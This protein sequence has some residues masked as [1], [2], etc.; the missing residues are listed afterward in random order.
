[1]SDNQKSPNFAFLAKHAP[2]LVD[3]AALAER[4]VFE[5]PNSALIKL[6]QLCEM[7]VK[8]AA[9][10]SGIVTEERDSI[11]VIINRLWDRRIINHDISSL[12]HDLRKAGNEAAHAHLDDRRIA[13]YQLQMARKLAVWFHK[14]F[15]KDRNF[16]AGPFLPPPDPV[17]Q[18]QTLVDELERLRKKVVFAEEQLSEEKQ[19]SEAQQQE[20]SEFK[21][22]VQEAY[23]NEEAALE[24]AADYEQRLQQEREEFEQ[25]L[26]QQQAEWATKTPEEQEAVTQHAQAEAEAFSLDEAETRQKIDAQLREAGWDA[27]SQ[28]LKYSAGI[29]PVKGRNIAIAE[30]PTK[31]GPADYVLFLGLT[32]VAVVEAKRKNKNVPASIEQSKRYS[33]NFQLPDDLQSPGGPWGKYQIPFLF[34]TN[35]RSYLRQIQE[36]SGIWL[37]D[38][39]QETNH[40]RALEGWYTPEGLKGL[41]K[42]DIPAANERLLSEPFHYLPLREY[43]KEAIQAVEQVIAAGQREILLAMATGTGKTITFIALLYRLIKAQRFRRILFLVDRTSLG[44]Q[45]GD[46]LKDLKLENLKTFTEIYDVKELG[47]LKPDEDTRLQVATVQGMVKRILYASD[48]SLPVPVDWYDCIIIDECHRGYNLDQLMSESELEFRSEEEY[49]SKYRRVL[50][51]FD[52]VR[53]G[54]TATPALHTNQIFG[55]PVYQYSYRQ[56]VIDGWLVDHEPPIRILTDLSH[57]GIKWERGDEVKSYDPVTHQV[58]LTNAP[59]DIEIEIE[60]FNRQVRTENFNKVVCEE[61]ANHL[62][63]ADKAKTL[64]FCVDDKHADLVVRLMKKALDQKYGGVHDDLVQKITGSVD[65]PLQKIRLY[66]N[67]QLPQIAV[68]VDLLTTGIDVP[69]IVNLVFLRR[70]NSRILFEQMLGRGTRLCPDLYGPDEDKQCF[71]IFDAVD[72]YAALQSLTNMT[73]V[74]SRPNIKFAQLSAELQTVTDGQFLSDVKDQFLAKLQRKRLN[75]HQEERLQLQT[76]LDRNGLIQQ[77]QNLEPDALGRWLAEHP[78]LPD[79]LD[80]VTARGTRI[81]ISEHADALHSTERG[82]GEGREKPEDYLESFKEYV[83][84]N[85]DRIAALTLVTQRP[86]EL[87]RQQLKEL[88][89]LLDEHGFTLAQLHSAWRETTNQDIAASI[90][91][92]IR[93]VVFDQPLVPHEERVEQA[94]QQVLSERDWT[95]QQRQWLERIGSQLKQEVIVDRASFDAGQFKARGGFQRL[96][97]VFQGELLEIIGHLSDLMW[98]TA[99]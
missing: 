21:A 73:P 60:K 78:N 53:I 27:D 32:P 89:L 46:K 2:L 12:M 18:Q 36:E 3:Y 30:W 76:G 70:V 1:M 45:A 74:V 16:K 77:V 95:S 51:H 61:L 80:E 59:D 28:V 69:E 55:M 29:R 6:R 71:R 50:E 91:G 57:N 90:I 99:A 41:L 15:G 14:S 7:L 40:P 82:Y 47:D 22:K 56:A 8:Q 87:T 42:Q 97:K 65:K 48:D 26:T 93:S 39:R 67:E 37:L 4:Y 98:E 81:L 33:R 13:L 49:I 94:V 9:A 35:G 66:K 38:A 85:P 34:A 92:Y 72:I 86:R 43:Q 17:D 64:I 20:L 75:E 62:D 83:T 11:Q 24:L 68:T 79:L 54:L 23:E 5:D 96:N 44:E 58:D 19:L 52:A 84:S 63:P 25:R 88:R 31:S 10:Y